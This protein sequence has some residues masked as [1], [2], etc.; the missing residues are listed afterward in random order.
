MDNS[1]R[2]DS[3]PFMVGTGP[4][5]DTLINNA[6]IVDTEPVLEGAYWPHMPVLLYEV[7]KTHHS[8]GC[9]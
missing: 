8:W 6:G 4:T 2:A 5:I 1:E 9:Q 7:A 3:F